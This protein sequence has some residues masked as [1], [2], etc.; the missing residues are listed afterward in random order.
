[1]L[2]AASLLVMIPLQLQFTSKSP[3][4]TMWTLPRKTPSTIGVLLGGGGGDRGEVGAAPP[5]AAR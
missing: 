2:P 5:T 4:P 3:T 1:M